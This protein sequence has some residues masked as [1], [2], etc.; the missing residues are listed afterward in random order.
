MGGQFG[1]LLMHPNAVDRLEYGGSKALRIRLIFSGNV[2]SHPVIWGSADKRQA[3][4]VVDPTIKMQNFEGDKPLV[5]VH[6]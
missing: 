3:A 2:Q 5:M 6:R 1:M 4:G